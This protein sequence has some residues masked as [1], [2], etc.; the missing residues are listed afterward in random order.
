[1]HDEVNHPQHCISSSLSSFA[2]TNS[3]FDMIADAMEYG[4]L[5]EEDWQKIYS[6][7]RERLLATEYAGEDSQVTA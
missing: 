7:T 2:L 3:A 4:R 1:M 5:T 6:A